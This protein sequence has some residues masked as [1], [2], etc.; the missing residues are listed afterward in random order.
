M[1][2]CSM[3]TQEQDERKRT[4]QQR[5]F[6]RHFDA[7]KFLSIGHDYVDATGLRWN[8]NSE[9]QKETKQ[10]RL[11]EESSD[12]THLAVECRQCESGADA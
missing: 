3:V 7:S 6:H 10:S 9:T 8:T 2:R 4:W 11:K 1:R 5:R 12:N